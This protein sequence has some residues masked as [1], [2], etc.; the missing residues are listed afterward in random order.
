[1]EEEFRASEADAIAGARRQEVEDL[2][3][4]DVDLDGDAR[5]GGA[6]GGR[7]PVLL[8][9]LGALSARLLA[10]V[11][12]ARR[13]LRGAEDQ[14][15]RFSVQHGL[16]AVRQVGQA[17]RE[18]DQEAPPGGTAQDFHGALRAAADKGHPA[19]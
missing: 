17:S 16:L 11:E 1:M 3:A 19:P 7:G 4:L 10:L 2:L 6:D 12:P 14:P 5:P 8:L 9:Q 13:D 15:P 18:A